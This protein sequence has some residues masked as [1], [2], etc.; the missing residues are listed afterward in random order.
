MIRPEMSNR[1]APRLARTSKGICLMLA[2]RM[3]RSKH[4]GTASA[5]EVQESLNRAAIRCDRLRRDDNLGAEAVQFLRPGGT[6]VSFPR[7]GVLGLSRA[8]EDDPPDQQ[9]QCES[10]AQSE[11]TSPVTSDPCRVATR[12][13]LIALISGGTPHI[14]TNKPSNRQFPCAFVRFSRPASNRHR[15]ELPQAYRA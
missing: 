10:E 13:L 8:S 4:A 3:A 5:A 15:S 2:F 14:N 11:A 7:A 9:S 6:D 12:R 1:I